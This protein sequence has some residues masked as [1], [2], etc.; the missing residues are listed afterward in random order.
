MPTGT[1]AQLT[2]FRVRTRSGRQAPARAVQVR[3]PRKQLGLPNGRQRQHRRRDRE[4]PGLARS[5]IERRCIGTTADRI[6][7]AAE[8]RRDGRDRCATGAPPLSMKRL[9][10]QHVARERQR[11]AVGDGEIER[12]GQARHARGRRGFLDDDLRRLIDASLPDP[13]A[14]R[15]RRAVAEAEFPV[16]TSGPVSTLTSTERDCPGSSPEN[17]S[18]QANA[19]VG[20]GEQIQS[21]PSGVALLIS[22]ADPTS[23]PERTVDASAKPTGP[24]SVQP[25][26]VSVMVQEITPPS[27]PGWHI[28]EM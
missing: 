11:A 21:T 5:E 9:S 18:W 28:F 19:E 8:R 13:R 24:V 20:V 16:A 14:A 12:A 17:G 3:R 15:A 7:C 27:G 10:E 2:A 23:G 4:R 26:L 1:H 25:T 22:T 6:G